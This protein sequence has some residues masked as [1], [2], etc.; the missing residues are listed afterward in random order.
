M[1][2]NGLKMRESEISSQPKCKE[3]NKSKINWENYEIIVLA[4]FFVFCCVFKLKIGD[5]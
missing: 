5:G 1:N 3:K 4:G 2:W